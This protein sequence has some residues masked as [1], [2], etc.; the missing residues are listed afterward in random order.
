LEV[1][2]VV[3]PHPEPKSTSTLP[4]QPGVLVVRKHYWAE[5]GYSRYD[6]M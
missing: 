6:G 3:L 5:R 2:A 1:K 4:E